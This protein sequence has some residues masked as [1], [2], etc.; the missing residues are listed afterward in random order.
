MRLL[1]ISHE[2]MLLPFAWRAHRQ[3]CEVTVHLGNPRYRKAW[4]GRLPKLD[5]PSGATL[6][7]TIASVREL[8][9]EQ[10]MWV[11]TD[12][13]NWT[14]VL[15][16]VPRVV[17]VGPSEPWPPS[18]VELTIGGW[19][20][21]ERWTHRHLLIAER[22]LWAGGLGPLLP[23]AILCVRP[24][25]WPE[26]WG[27]IL[28]RLQDRLKAAS[29]L[30]FAQT[31][32]QTPGDA[33]VA[34]GLEAGWPLFQA[35]AA[36]A[37]PDAS[38]EALLAGEDA[39]GPPFALVMPVSVPPWPFQARGRAPEAPRPV[40]F[41][42]DATRYVFFHDIAVEGEELRTAGLGGLVGVV[43]GVART[44]AG[45]KLM[46]RRIAVEFNVAERQWRT[47]AGDLAEQAWTTLVELGAVGV[48]LGGGG[49][50]TQRQQSSPS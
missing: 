29:F 2:H 3:G 1:V 38:I 50:V 36:L 28:E 20:T 35:H 10:E 37:D 21:G 8:A 7:A 16:G 22:G 44:P 13:R 4:E 30:G 45:A 33:W 14:A 18:P 24:A 42:R 47:D 31:R 46:A 26:A 34:S 17:G 43:R 49:V 48:Y 40:G 41:P 6:E 9:L 25:E 15:E 27:D 19:W 39:A 32:L 23:G 12:S 11:L 5:I